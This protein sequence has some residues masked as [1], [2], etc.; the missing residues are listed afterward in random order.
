[1]KIQDLKPRLDAF[2]QDV[3]EGLYKPQK[4]LPSKYFYDEAGSHLFEQI[5]K[6]DEYY[7]PRTERAIME[8]HIAEIAALLGRYAVLIDYG[9]GDG[10]KGRFLLNYLEEPA[11]YV[12]VDICRE[13]LINI[14]DNL[15]QDC[16]NLEVMPV[17]ADYSK[18]FD[19]P[20][21]QKENGRRVVYFPGS[22]IGNFNPP[23]A[24]SFLK[25]IISIYGQN[26]SLLIGVDLKK[27]PNVL[28][29]AYND[30][31]NITAEFNLNMLKRMNRELEANFDL[32]QFEHQA[33]YNP[34]A[35]RVEMHLASLTEQQVKINNTTIPFAEGE[36]IWT[37]SSYK[38]SLA[39]FEKLA[40]AAGF[41]VKR[42]WT[43]DEKLFSVQYLEQAA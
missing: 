27:D 17:C 12:P 14:T 13:Q 35:G 40:A 10:Q 11:I 29:K 5:C 25:R 41:S 34:E 20:L 26:A 30:S 1:M 42:V 4:E 43:D 8:T 31:R 21:P 32:S 9:C 6:L 36:S 23:N 24:I 15:N 37:E 28:N 39:E 16:P 38:Y 18:N 22:S 3:L 33:F 7:I 2:Y 19:L